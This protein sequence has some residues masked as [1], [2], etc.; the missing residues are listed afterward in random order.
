VAPGGMLPTGRSMAHDAAHE[1]VERLVPGRADNPSALP[2]AKAFIVQF[3]EGTDA[4]PGNV[5]GRV[6]H[7]QRGRRSR[8]ASVDELLAWIMAMLA[9]VAALRMM[10][11]RCPISRSGS[12]R[13]PPYQTGHRRDRQQGGRR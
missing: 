1:G 11:E 4:R 3:D 9:G 6:E 7:L 2:Y 10:A 12:L 5:S 13:C 8:F